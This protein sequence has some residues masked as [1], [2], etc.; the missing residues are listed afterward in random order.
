MTSHTVREV[1]SMA[2]NPFGTMYFISS[3]GA[4]TLMKRDSLSAHFS[5]VPF[6]TRECGLGACNYTLT[7]TVPMMVPTLS[8]C[9]CTMCPLLRPSIAAARSRFTGEPE[10]RSPRFVSRSVSGAHP[11]LNMDASNSVTVRQTP[12]TEMEHP[13]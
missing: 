2:M 1:P 9:P 4:L 13:S 12:L 3:V 10:L 5:V 11:T 8:T 7:F 6:A